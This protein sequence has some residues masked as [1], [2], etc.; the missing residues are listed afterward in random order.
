MDKLIAV[1]SIRKMIYLIR[2][3]KV[4]I[5]TDLASLYGVEVRV[6][7]QAVKRNKNRF[8]ADFMFQLTAD[9]SRN[10]KSQNVISSWGGA[11]R[12][13]PYAFTEQGVAMLSSVLNSKRAIQVNI[14]IMRAFVKLR[15]IISAHKE[16]LKKLDELQNKVGKHDTQIMAIFRAIKQMMIKPPL[17]KK[18]YGFRNE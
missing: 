9:E 11:R 13:E 17:G 16:L 10:L 8:P 4:I 15:E 2:G 5:S 3:Q 12:A 1:D 6:L 18:K 14:A 7:I